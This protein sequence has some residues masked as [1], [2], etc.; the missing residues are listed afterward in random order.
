MFRISLKCCLRW[1]RNVLVYLI[2]LLIL[3]IYDG[4]EYRKRQFV[5]KVPEYAMKFILFEGVMNLT[6]NVTEIRRIINYTNTNEEILNLDIYGPI[7]SDTVILVIHI[8]K[9]T[10][11]L[12]YLLISLSQTRGIEDA[13]L[14]FS[15]SHLDENAMNLIRKIDFCRVLQIL[16]PY[17]VQAYPNEF[18]GFHVHDCPHNMDIK[19][20]EAIECIGTPDIHGR[21]RNPADAAKKHHWWWTAN[22]VFENL[23]CMENHE[24]IVIFLEDDFYVMEDFLYMALYMKK[25]AESLPQCEF[26]SLGTLSG[27]QPD[28]NDTYRVEVTTWDP[29]YHSNVLVLDVTA[30][31][32]IVTH[33]DLFCRVDDFSWSRSLFYLSLMRKDGQRFKVMSS[34][35]PRAYKISYSSFYESLVQ[36]NVMETIYRILDLQEQNKLYMYPAHLEIYTDIEMENDEFIIFDYVEGNGGWSDPRDKAL[37]T[38]MTMSKIKKVLLDMKIEFEDYQ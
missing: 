35:L 30:W 1:L 22:K 6:E 14:I 8:H 31:N 5:D 26:L 23:T 19:T 25:A 3:V 11:Y 37:C 21:Y 16:Y 18:P 9:L 13:L 12:K 34:K 32:S 33:Y 4:K 10:S 7:K 15:H 28:E 38:N 36:F 29:R 27:P 20:A 2:L 17:S 24:G